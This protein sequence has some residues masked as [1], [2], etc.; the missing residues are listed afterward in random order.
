MEVNVVHFLVGNSTVVL[1]D[2]VARNRLWTFNVQPKSLDKLLGHRQNVSQ[3]LVRQF[4]QL[5]AMVLWNDQ[6]MALGCRLDVE[7]GVRVGSFNELERW[8]LALDDFTEDTG[9]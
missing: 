4:V 6:E 8:N 7:E 9:S 3:I 1:Q 5:S 2:V